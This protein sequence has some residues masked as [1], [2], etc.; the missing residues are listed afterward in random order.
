MNTGNEGKNGPNSPLYTLILAAYTLEIVSC[1]YTDQD[2]C[3]MLFS[4]GFISKLIGWLALHVLFF[5]GS[6]HCFVVS[7]EYNSLN[8][9]AIT[10][11]LTEATVLMQPGQKNPVFNNFNKLRLG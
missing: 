6:V 2:D 8:I 9:I 5:C 1:L 10:R 11:L 7:K 4:L 3:Y